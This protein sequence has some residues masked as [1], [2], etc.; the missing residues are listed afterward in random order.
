[1]Q[2]PDQQVAVSV[3]CAPDASSPVRRTLRAQEIASRSSRH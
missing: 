3:V 2:S 1:M